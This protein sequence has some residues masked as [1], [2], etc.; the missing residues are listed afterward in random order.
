MACIRGAW[1]LERFLW[2]FNDAMFVLTTS[3][4]FNSS[5]NWYFA[6]KGAFVGLPA[7]FLAAF[8]FYFP[9]SFPRDA[10]AFAHIIVT[11]PENLRGEKFGSCP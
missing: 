7:H 5:L 3:A 2:A 11:V 1:A 4:I 9:T 10:S 8:P 6:L